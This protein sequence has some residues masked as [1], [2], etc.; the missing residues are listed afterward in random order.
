MELSAVRT[1]NLYARVVFSDPGTDRHPNTREVR[2]S[3]GVAES[4]FRE[5]FFVTQ[6]VTTGD[7]YKLSPPTPV[8]ERIGLGSPLE[9]VLAVPPALAGLT[10]GIGALVTL[11]ERMATFNAKVDRDRAMYEAEAAEFRQALN[12]RQ[13][14]AFSKTVVRLVADAQARDYRLREVEL[15]TDDD[16]RAM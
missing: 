6:W 1:S 8:V 11:A 13:K 4:L 2:G 12:E 5:A 9:I 7:E 15:S 10:Y 16:E 14:Q 3:F